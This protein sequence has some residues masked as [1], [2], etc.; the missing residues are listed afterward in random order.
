MKIETF[1]WIWEQIQASID[2]IMN[3]FDASHLGNSFHFRL[4]HGEETENVIKNRYIEIRDQLKRMCYSETE[5]DEARLDQ[6]KLAAC[7]C[8]AIID[9]KVFAFDIND[10]TPPEMIRSNYELAYISG[11]RIV[12]IYMMDYYSYYYG[13]DS[14]CVKWL[15]QEKGLYGPPTTHDSYHLGRIKT[16]ALNDYYGVEFD[17]LSYADMMF[18]IEYYNRQKIENKIEIEYKKDKKDKKDDAGIL[19]TVNA[20]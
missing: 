14:K 9:K 4:L 19:G 3:R 12:Q 15:K 10:Q 6:H 13:E 5:Y 7:F 17:I 18:W 16:L 20:N 8:K 1:K 2:E 11:L